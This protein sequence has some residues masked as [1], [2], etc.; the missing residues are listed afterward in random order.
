M[1][2]MVE[3]MGTPW[4]KHCS[5]G[6]VGAS[7]G[8]G[9]AITHFAQRGQKSQQGRVERGQTQKLDREAM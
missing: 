9:Q 1:V 5:R 8:P 2:G 3:G 4:D 7:C 6:T